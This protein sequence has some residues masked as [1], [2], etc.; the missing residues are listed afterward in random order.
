VAP[1][2]YEYQTFAKERWIGRRLA[3]VF[4]QEFRDRPQSY[5]VDQIHAGRILVNNKPSSMDYIICNSDLIS[6]KLHRHEP[7]VVD[8]CIE[9]LF[10]DGNMLVINKP[11]S[12]PVHPSGRYNANSLVEMLKSKYG[13]HHLSII[14]RLDRLVS[15]IVILAVHP[16][17]ARDLH[18]LMVS[19]S[20]VKEYVCVVKGDFAR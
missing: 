4:N 9:I 14:N 10:F 6:H 18:N 5:Y 8:A 20:L 19:S 13:L 3:D 11:S 16:T 15:G 17:S 12:I 2:P 7:P 1:Y